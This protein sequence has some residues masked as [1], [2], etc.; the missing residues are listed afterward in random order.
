[1]PSSF[2][3]AVDI[4]STALAPSQRITQSSRRSG[5]VID[6]ATKQLRF[7]VWYPGCPM[8]EDAFFTSEESRG[9]WFINIKDWSIPV[10]FVDAD[11]TPKH[12]VGD[13]RPGWK[14]LRVLGNLLEVLV[15]FIQAYIFTM[16]TAVFTGMGMGRLPMTLLFMI[17]AFRSRCLKS[18]RAT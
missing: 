4:T 8:E 5:S 18:S 13:S 15:A 16:L 17:Q 2:A 7:H 12:D 1:M 9:A 6:R 11:N 14:V 3:R 10:Y